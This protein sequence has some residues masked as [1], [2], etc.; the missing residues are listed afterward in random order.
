MTTHIQC[1]SGRVAEIQD[2]LHDHPEH[3]RTTLCANSGKAEGA[4]ANPDL[5][6]VQ[7]VLDALAKCHAETYR[8]FAE[9]LGIPL[10]DIQVKLQGALDLRGI[11]AAADHVRPGFTGIEATVHLSSPAD[12]YEVERL[13]ITVERHAPV[14]H[15]L[16]N[17]TP[18]KIELVITHCEN[19][20]IA[21]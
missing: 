7:R 17:P 18:V 12:I 1:N 6:P 16:R 13:R 10:I 20:P 21:A 9:A 5:V 19:P 11:Y 15:M 14:L 2:A 3:A 8:L 4:V